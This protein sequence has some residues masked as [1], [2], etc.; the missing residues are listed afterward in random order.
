MSAMSDWQVAEK[1]KAIDGR[2][3]VAL[4]T[5]WN[6]GLEQ[7]E[8]KESGKQG[9]FNENI[10]VTTTLT[11]GAGQTSPIVKRWRRRSK[12]QEIS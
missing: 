6:I 9:S 2:V 4:I 5:G 3:P 10:Q 1:V 11:N 8:M 12:K 7:S